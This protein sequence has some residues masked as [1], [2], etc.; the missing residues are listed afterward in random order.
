[1]ILY[2]IDVRE[3]DV[4][5]TIV[6]LRGEFDLASLERLRATLDAV[7]HLRKPAL[8]DLSGITFLDLGCARELAV[9]SQL[10]AHCLTLRNPSRPTLATVRACDL[11]GWLNLDPGRDHTGPPVFSEI[12]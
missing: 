12:N 6:G 4:G 3:G 11:E 10:Y 5:D 2:S 9:R 1:V 7:A 8:V